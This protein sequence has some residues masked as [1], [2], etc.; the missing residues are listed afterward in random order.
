MEIYNA[1]VGFTEKRFPASSLI[2][3]LLQAGVMKIAQGSPPAQF[4]QS[5]SGMYVQSGDRPPFVSPGQWEGSLDKVTHISFPLSLPRQSDRGNAFI[6]LFFVL[7]I[8]PMLS[9]SFLTGLP[10]DFGLIT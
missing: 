5:F 8:R 4:P 6:F 1:A 3:I 9:T 7:L 10:I 2:I